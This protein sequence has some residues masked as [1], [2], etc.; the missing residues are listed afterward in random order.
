MTTGKPTKQQVVKALSH[1]QLPGAPF[2]PQTA[3]EIASILVKAGLV[4]E[5]LLEEGWYWVRW[6]TGWGWEPRYT[7]TDYARNDWGKGPLTPAIIGPRI[8]PP[9]ES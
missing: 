5:P 9:S 1:G 3:A 8:T 7:R 4:E 6:E 2:G